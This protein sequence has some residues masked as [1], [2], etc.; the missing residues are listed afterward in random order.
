ME[1][2]PSFDSSSILV[3]KHYVDFNKEELSSSSMASGL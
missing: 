2:I 3:E 1:E